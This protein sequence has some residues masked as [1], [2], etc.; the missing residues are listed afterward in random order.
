LDG[1]G[2][3][4]F[5]T[6]NVLPPLHPGSTKIDATRRKGSQCLVATVNLLDM[7]VNSRRYEFVPHRVIHPTVRFRNNDSPYHSKMF[8]T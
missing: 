3:G 5:W 6:L 7:L 1:G 4:G 2:G 8:G